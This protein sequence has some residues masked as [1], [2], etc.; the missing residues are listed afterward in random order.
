MM[1]IN[2]GLQIM[3]SK[4]MLNT[5]EIQLINRDDEMASIRNAIAQVSAKSETYIA[6]GFGPE[7]F[8]ER[9]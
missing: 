6:P 5:E 2:G 8:T 7:A 3:K 1:E 4:Y 9:E